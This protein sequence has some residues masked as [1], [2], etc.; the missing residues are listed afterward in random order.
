MIDSIISR[1]MDYK[2]YLRID[3]SRYNY[4]NELKHRYQKNNIGQP[5]ITRP[6]LNQENP[7]TI[8]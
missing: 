5:I 3:R 2:L 8:G 1:L 7:L 4:T 6:I